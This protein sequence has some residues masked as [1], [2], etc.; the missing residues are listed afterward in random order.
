MF[1]VKLNVS[2]FFVV[3]TKHHNSRWLPEH[4]ITDLTNPIPCHLQVAGF[5]A[6][7]SES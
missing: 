3:V 2:G 1:L 4:R 7:I 6:R 5:S